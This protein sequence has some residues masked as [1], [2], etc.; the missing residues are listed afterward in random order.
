MQLTPSAPL[1]D[2]SAGEVSMPH[3]AQKS[4]QWP[5]E[6]V[7]K[8]SSSLPSGRVTLKDNTIL[9]PGVLVKLQY[10]LCILA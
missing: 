7:C 10:S 4:L 1:K 2:H 5:M 6:G 8:Y 3:P 9:A